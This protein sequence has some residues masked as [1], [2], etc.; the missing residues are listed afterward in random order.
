MNIPIYVKP[1]GK[2]KY[3]FVNV[4][5][6]NHAM[7]TVIETLAKRLDEELNKTKSLHK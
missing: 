1:K 5:A 7:E 4:F 2:S 6:S 3:T